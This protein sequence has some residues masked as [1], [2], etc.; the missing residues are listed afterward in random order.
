M[1]VWYCR[2][3]YTNDLH[4]ALLR[5]NGADFRKCWRS[6]FE[7]PA[8]CVGL[9]VD[10]CVDSDIV[11]EKFAEHFSAAYTPNKTDEDAVQP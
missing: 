3:P 10:G 9:R 5:K 8:K 2:P 6:N 1:W 4:D 11:A 7:E